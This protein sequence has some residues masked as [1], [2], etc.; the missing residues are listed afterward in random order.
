MPL[1]HLQGPVPQL[2]GVEMQMGGGEAS[3]VPRGVPAYIIDRLPH[4]EYHKASDDAAG[5]EAYAVG[6]TVVFA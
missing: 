1:L 3:V 2:N 5:Q 6:C 4:M